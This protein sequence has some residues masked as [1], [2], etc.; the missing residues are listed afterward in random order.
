M[1]LALLN[2]SI[3]RSGKVSTWAFTVEWKT[4][5]PP[6]SFIWQQPHS[7]IICRICL[8]SSGSDRCIFHWTCTTQKFLHHPRVQCRVVIIIKSPTVH[9]WVPLAHYNLLLFRLSLSDGLSLVKVHL[10]TVQLI[11]FSLLLSSIY[12]RTYHFWI[13]CPDFRT[14]SSFRLYVPFFQPS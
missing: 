9:D 2:L 10:L 5:I 11:C 6:R 7:I 3:D 12:F 4:A 14:S 8:F 13:F 1:I